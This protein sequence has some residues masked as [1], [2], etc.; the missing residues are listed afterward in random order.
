MILKVLLHSKQPREYTRKNGDKVV[1]ESALITEAGDGKNPPLMKFLEL[2]GE[3]KGWE[4][5]T[6][7]E[8]LV[9]DIRSLFSGRVQLVGKVLGNGK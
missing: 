2:S 1:E 6:V 8:V 3:F 4:V 5:G 7:R 9:T